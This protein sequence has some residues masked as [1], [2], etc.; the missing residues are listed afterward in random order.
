MLLTQHWFWYLEYQME[1]INDTLK[2]LGRY[3]K[4]GSSHQQN[5]F[6][7]KESEQK[8]CLKNFFKSQKNR[9]KEKKNT[10]RDLEIRIRRYT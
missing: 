9:K 1:G 3:Y 6:S 7:S 2:T 8:N 4:K 5:S 10:V